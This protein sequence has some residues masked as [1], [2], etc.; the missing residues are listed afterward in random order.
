[1]SFFPVGRVVENLKDYIVKALINTVDHLGSV[2]YKLNDL[3]SN[4]I[5]DI[6]STQLRI[7]SLNQACLYCGYLYLVY[8]NTRISFTDILSLCILG[9]V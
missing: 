5:D 4:Q 7:T 1:M 8:F 2:S 9:L 6:S 3:L